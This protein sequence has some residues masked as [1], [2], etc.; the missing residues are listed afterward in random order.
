LVRTVH[1]AD[2]LLLALNFTMDELSVE[3]AVDGVEVGI[4]QLITN[5]A[6][7]FFTSFT[8]A[9][10][11][12][13]NGHIHPVVR[14]LNKKIEGLLANLDT[15]PKCVDPQSDPS[16]FNQ[17]STFY[18][19]IGAAGLLLIVG[20]SIMIIK[21]LHGTSSVQ[22]EDRAP[23][24]EKAANT[25]IP[26]R[27][28]GCL[29]LSNE[30]P[31]VV[32]YGIFAL[33]LANVALFI[34]SNTSVGASV[35]LEIKPRD[36]ETIRFP[37][38]FDFSL[39]NSVR[40]MWNAKVYALSILIAVFSGFWPYMKLALLAG[41]WLVP[42]GK[43]VDVVHRERVLL[44]L[45]ALGKCSFI[46]SFVMILMMVA[47]HF[48]ISPIVSP[49]TPA[50][51]IVVQTWVEP[52]YGFFSFIAATMS[53]LLITHFVVYYHRKV[54][55]KVDHSDSY[56]KK[57]LQAYS[58]RSHKG[59]SVLLL[60]VAPLL[61]IAAALVALG[62]SIPSFEFEFKGAFGYLLSLLQYPTTSSFSVVSLGG[63]IPSSS[64]A[65]HS[66]GTLFLQVS[67]F[68]LICAMPLVYLTLLVILWLWPFTFRAQRRLLHIT[69]IAQAWASL[70]VFVVA[71]IAALLEL[72]QFAQFIL[73]DRCDK[74]NPLLE[75][76]AQ[77]L[78]GS[79]YKCFDV[80]ASLKTGCWVMFSGCIIYVFVGAL[81]I[82]F[83][84]K[85]LKYRITGENDLTVN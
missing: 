78:I 29:M 13:I 12:F 26:E 35:Y 40:D 7:L 10:P 6:N 59:P 66:V 52:H 16:T 47:F 37:S 31:V 36:M 48:S 25:T 19:L 18:A 44:V 15:F 9:I 70:E 83:C 27:S 57:S 30:I 76:Y 69:E 49:Y 84:H 62:I 14:H 75:K 28:S 72:Q 45:D 11:A 55:E 32:R 63:F 73:G 79:D 61:V 5:V 67:F 56:E 20:A 68:L 39:G 82:K 54:S 8:P 71:V 58:R 21:Y 74:I 24:L 2:I 64:D 34:S 23:F 42:V 51:T 53:S 38:L 80:A 33:I 4:D 85:A 3:S 46:D 41:C 22:Q 77:P 43:F 81:V 50:D 60:F 65:P 17:T 1:A